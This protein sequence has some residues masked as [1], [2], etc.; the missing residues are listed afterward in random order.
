METIA[1]NGPRFIEPIRCDYFVL[2]SRRGFYFPA[3]D[4]LD[5]HGHPVFEIRREGVSLLRVFTGE[6]RATAIR[7][8]RNE[9]TPRHLRR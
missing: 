2:Q 8:T 4:W 7:D 3:D 6:E 9:R 1:L 5:Q